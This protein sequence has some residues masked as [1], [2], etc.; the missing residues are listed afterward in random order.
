M[1]FAADGKEFGTILDCTGCR[2]PF[3]T[4]SEKTG[5]DVWCPDCNLGRIPPNLTDRSVV[6]ATERE[7][8]LALASE[9][10][11]D[12]VTLRLQVKAQE[13]PEYVVGAFQEPELAPD[14][15]TR[16]SLA[17]IAQVVADCGG[18]RFASATGPDAWAALLRL[19]LE[20]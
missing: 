4:A 3:L 17:A 2:L 14:A 6:A 20:P 11:A 9:P 19:P 8:Q 1:R 18:H 10:D 15:P 7:V 5:P 16:A 12:E 13:L